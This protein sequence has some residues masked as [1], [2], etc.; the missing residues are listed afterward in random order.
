MVVELA[1]PFE[2]PIGETG[3]E[4]ALIDRLV[5]RLA[6]LPGVDAVTPVLIHPFSGVGAF[7][8]RPTAEG[9]SPEEARHNPMLNIEVVAPNYFST[10]GISVLRGRAF[11]NAD[12]ED[13]PPVV[14][15]SEA[16]ARHYWPKGDPLGRRLLSMVDGRKTATVVGVVPETR[17]RDLRE[18]RPTIYYPM[19]QGLFPVAPTTLVMRLGVPPERVIPSVRRVVADVEEHA[20][21]VR[22]ATFDELLDAPRAQPRLNALLLSTFAAAALLLAAIGLYAVM[23]TMVRQRT[24][25]L[26]VRI[27]LGARAEDLVRLVVRRGLILAMTGAV[28]GLTGALATNRALESLLFQVSPADALTLGIVTAAMLVVATMASAVPA[29]WTARIDPVIA[30]RSDS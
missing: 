1:L 24:R 17:Y 18:A 8:G 23:A 3:K 25:E 22:A 30:L 2:Q 16:A 19:S 27:A 4:T 9:Q 14:I 20:A 7:D 29:R 13:T 11:T 5:P 15:L 6:A 28:A 26:G 12:R 10:L 21:V